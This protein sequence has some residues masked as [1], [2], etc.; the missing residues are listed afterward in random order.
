MIKAITVHEFG[1]PEV[2]KLEDIDIA[3]PGHDEVRIKQTAIAVNYID[4]YYR[5]SLYPT[6]L[7]F[8]PGEEG[9][10]IIEQLGD[11]VT[12]FKIGDRVAYATVSLGAYSSS[13]NINHKALIPIPDELSDQ[14]VASS[15]T[16]GLTAEYL[17]FRCHQLQAGQSILV[18]AAAGG[19]G[20]LTCQWAKSMGATVFGTVGDASKINA[21]KQ[22]GC[23]EVIVYSEQ[24]VSEVIKDKTRGELLDVVYD[25]IGK[26]TLSE[27]IQCVKPRGLLVSFGNASGAPEPVAVLQ[28]S[29]Q[30]SIYLTRPR[31]VDYTKD[32]SELLKSADRYFVALREG[33]VR[34]PEYIT[35]PL[36]QAHKAHEMIEDRH[37]KAL[38]VLVP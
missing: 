9:A 8:V 27:S 2:L 3:D 32:R 13:R 5:T 14:Q 12:D 36:E 29:R 35:L 15:L 34:I 19:V 4:T 6:K 1:G 33:E 38:P 18:H 22:N 11:S 24:N 23:D 7:P 20:S 26:A 10:G 31:L 17:L 25:G 16:R 21:A 37:K 28:L 30:G